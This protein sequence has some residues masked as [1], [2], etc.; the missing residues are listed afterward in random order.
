M[1]FVDFLARRRQNPRM[2]W[3]LLFLLLANCV[4][5]AEPGE[6]EAFA[7]AAKASQDSF[8]ER[9]EKAWADFLTRFPKSDRRAEAALAQAQARHQMKNFSGALELLTTRLPEAGA[10][11]DQYKFWRGQTFLDMTNYSSAE[12]TFAEFLK[13]DTN[14]PLRL[15]AAVGQGTARFKKAD[16]SGVVDLLG[17]TNGV[18]Q[19]IAAA[20]TNVAQVARGFL[21]LAESQFRRNDLAAARTTLQSLGFK[22]LPPELEWERAQTLARVEFASDTPE[23]ALP[24]LTNAVARARA[25]KRSALIAE[26]LNLEAEV[27]KRL[28][29]PDRAAL[30]YAGIVAAE[31]MPLDQKRI[32]LLKQVE[33]SAAQNAFTNAAVTISAFLNQNPADPSAD[34]LQIKAGEFFLEAYRAQTNKFTAPATN[35]LADARNLFDATIQKYTNSA[36]LGKAWLNKGWTLWEEHEATGNRQSLAESQH[37]FQLAAEKLPPGDD[38]AM[39][40]LKAGDVQFKQEIFSGAVTN[41]EAVLNAFA[42]TPSIRT[43]IA[44]KAAE[45]LVRAHLAMTNL[46]AADAALQKTVALF[47]SSS[48]AQQSWLTMAQICADLG[49]L[50]RARKLLKDFGTKFPGSSLKSDAELSHARTFALENKWPEAIDLYTKWTASNPTHPALA[51]AEFDRAWFHSK[52]GQETNAFQAFTNFVTRFP[53][54]VLAAR[55]QYWIGNYY[56]NPPREQWPLA[57]QSYQQVFQSTNWS[58]PDLAC[59]ARMAAARTAF[60][61]QSYSDAKNH[62]TNLINSACSPDIVAE[63]WFVLG[64][65]LIEERLP[66]PTNVL[67]N[68][69]QARI[70]FDRITR[71]GPTNRFEPLAWGKIGDCYFQLAA[72]DPPSYL[73]ATNAYFKVLESKRSDVPVA[74]RNQA[75][76]GIALTLDKMSENRPPKEAAALQQQALDHLLNV[77]YAAGGAEPDDHWK[78]RAAQNA[79]RLAEKLKPEAARELYTRLIQEMPAMKSTWEAKRALLEAVPQ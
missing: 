11:A 12:E 77:V 78:K 76:V 42:A 52:A 71:M 37:A 64:D 18:F 15:N 33:L 20:S 10:F 9:A 36:H 66:N 60:F 55:V 31:G 68:F 48:Y 61:R 53:T 27:H 29:R 16:F 39:A 14:S 17:N 25:T 73:D 2:R 75:E 47:P 34:S 56:F 4:F 65:V 43:N 13:T 32:A 57:E 28:N 44:G 50:Q 59:Q 23:Q 6:S 67:E 7:A 8:Y 35:Y 1:D 3:L 5:A 69:K 74:A 70:A 21:L 54:N 22:A 51:Q 24:A 46:T 41:F 40:R 30:A 38:Q 72:A 45:Q 63:A 79:A 62:L 19:Q 58:V 49:D 26:T